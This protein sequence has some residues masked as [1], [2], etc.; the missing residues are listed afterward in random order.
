M[1]I[2]M[3]AQEPKIATTLENYQEAL[4]LAQL[5]D[6]VRGV[7]LLHVGGQRLKMDHGNSGSA[8]DSKRLEPDVLKAYIDKLGADYYTEDSTGRNDGYPIL[9]WELEG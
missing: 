6:N 1:F 2:N 8:T 4:E 5:Q 7:A 3:E 9:K